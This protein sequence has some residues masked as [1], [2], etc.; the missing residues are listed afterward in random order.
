L[1]ATTQDDCLN[2]SEDCHYALSFYE[3]DDGRITSA[4]EYWV[5]EAYEE[6]RAERARWFEPM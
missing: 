3:V 1:G 6:P 5:M 2:V 4:R